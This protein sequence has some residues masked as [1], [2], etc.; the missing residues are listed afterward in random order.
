VTIRIYPSRLPGESLETHH[1]ETRTL[2]AW[3]AQNVKDWT[4]DQQ[5]P[6]AVEIDGVPVPPAEWAL[7]AIRPDSDI[8]MY[9]VPYGTGAE[10]ALWV[11]VS[12]AVASAAYSIY[13]MSTMQTGGASQPSNGDQLE[14]NPAK[15]NMAKLGDP[16][17][18]IF[19]RYKVWP[20][21]VVQPVSRFDSADPKKYVTSMFLCVGAGDM[22]LPASAIRIGSTPT[23]AFGSDVSATIYPPGAS[24]L[25]DSRSENWRGG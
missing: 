17:R 21:Y 14:L 19:G 16:I 5:H 10:I 18:E 25:A 12:V 2:N 3:F 22:A 11:A 13:M 23:S 24:V 6:V 1:H 4:P 15:A 7:C 20:D 8:R 9:P